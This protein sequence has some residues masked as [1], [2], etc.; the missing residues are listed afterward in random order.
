MVFEDLKVSGSLPNRKFSRAI[1]DWGFCEFR[2]QLEYKS[3]L[4]GNYVLPADLER[5]SAPGLELARFIV[6]VVEQLNTESLDSS[7]GD[8]GLYSYPPKMMLALLFY[9]YATRMF[10]SRKIE[11]ATYNL[12]PVIYITN[13]K[14]PDHG[15]I[16][17]F[18][19]FFRKD[20][21]EL[22]RQILLIANGIGIFKLGYINVDGT[23]A[24]ASKSRAIGWD[25]ANELEA[26][27][28]EEIGK[29]MELAGCW[30]KEKPGGIEYS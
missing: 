4:K 25:Y 7:Y 18:R 26:Q 29:L 1:A 13:G 27:L 10:S 11:T 5:F 20:L 22:F 23:K 21:E 17:T 12:I 14:H 16:N 2:R 6:E 9:C 8:W 28:K 15:T 3:S 19:K 24:N 30:N